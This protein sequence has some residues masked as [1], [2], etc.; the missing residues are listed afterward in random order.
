MEK[1]FSIKKILFLII[2][3]IVFFSCKE[4]PKNH[5]V[6]IPN[7]DTIDQRMMNVN[8]ILESNETGKIEDY[9]KRYHWE[10]K[11]STSGLK[12]MIYI[13]GNGKHPRKNCKIKIKYRC[14]LLNGVT[15]YNSDIDGLKVFSIGKAE[16]ETGLEEGILLLKVG[17]KAKF[18]IPSRLA[19]GLIGDQ[20]KIPKKA[21]LVYDV[22]LLEVI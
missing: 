16:V 3:G 22:E 2:V 12:Y 8:I 21:T 4:Q 15:V 6:L 18:I 14:S 20:K 1:I 10:M 5:K 11:T 9:I 17:D 19:F 7:Q 13:Q